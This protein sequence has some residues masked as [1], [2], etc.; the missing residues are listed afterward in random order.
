M[1]RVSLFLALGSIALFNQT[2]HA[3][4]SFFQTGASGGGQQFAF[5]LINPISGTM[6]APVPRFNGGLGTIKVMHKGE[7]YYVCCSGCKDEFNAEP[8]KYIRLAAEK[9]KK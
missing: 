4:I 2:A 1:C 8:E 7:A 5:A 9:K 3:D 6:T